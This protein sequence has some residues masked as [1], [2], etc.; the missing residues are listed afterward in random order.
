MWHSVL[1]FSRVRLPRRDY[2]FQ[3]CLACLSSINTAVVI[4]VAA[5]LSLASILA[6]SIKLLPAA[7]LSQFPHPLNWASSMAPSSVEVPWY[8]PKQTAV[9]DLTQV[10]THTGVYGFLYNSSETP[11]EIYG[12]YN[13]CNMPHV[14]AR[15]Y[16]K[17]DEEYQLQYVE[18]VRSYAFAWPQISS[19]QW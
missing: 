9:N 3:G 11:D 13:W 14:R 10:F 19:V 1:G 5:A 8:T 4:S 17:L 7:A 18:V 6:V 16:V 2:G 12:I 15:E